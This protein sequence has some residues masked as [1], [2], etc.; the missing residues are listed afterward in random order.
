M[1][2]L[3]DGTKAFYANNK[4]CYSWYGNAITCYKC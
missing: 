4:R 1:V 3:K 2:V